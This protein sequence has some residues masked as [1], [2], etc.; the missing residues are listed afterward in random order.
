MEKH[1]SG[2]GFV[3]VI[4][5]GSGIYSHMTFIS[6]LSRKIDDILVTE[7][8]LTLTFPILTTMYK[9]FP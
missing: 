2:I 4:A 8:L 9:F 7:G 5:V 6:N 1:D 3:I